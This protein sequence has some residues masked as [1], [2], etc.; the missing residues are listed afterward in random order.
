[1]TATFGDYLSAR[2]HAW[3]TGSVACTYNETEY[4]KEWDDVDHR[5]GCREDDAGED[6]PECSRCRRTFQRVYG[7][8]ALADP[9]ERVA[10]FLAYYSD[11]RPTS[12]PILTVAGSSTGHKDV[13]LMVSDLRHLVES[14]RKAVQSATEAEVGHVAP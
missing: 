2:A 1:M 8:P 4:R 9:V 7:D 14:C 3:V 11:G 12:S 10:R 5:I 6:A 13:T